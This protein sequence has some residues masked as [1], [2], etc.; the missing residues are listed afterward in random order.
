MRINKNA[1]DIIVAE[2]CLQY[3]EVAEKAGISTNCIYG[4]TK[5]NVTPITVGKIAKALDVPVQDIIIPEETACTG[6]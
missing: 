2:R 4:A 5:N 6:E 3:K 1:L